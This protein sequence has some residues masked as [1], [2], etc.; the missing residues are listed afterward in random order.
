[1]NENLQYFIKS[2]GCT[3]SKN[4]AQIIEGLLIN[5]GFKKVKSIDIA[6]IIIINTCVVKINTENKILYLISKISKQMPEKILIITGCMAEVMSDRVT[7]IS[8][9]ANLIGP[10]YI[11]EIIKV[12]NEFKQNLRPIKL[13]G[14]RV[15]DKLNQ[16][17]QVSNNLIAI[18]PISQGCVNTCN[19]CIVKKA[20]G[21]LKSYP[22]EV[23]ISNISKVTRNGVKEI[24]LTAQDLS[25]Y[26]KDINMKLTDI[27]ERINNI[28]GKFR[29]RLGMM[30]P[31]TLL[32]NIDNLSTICK[33]DKF[34]K[35][36]HIPI[37]S[38][39]NEILEKMNRK[40]RIEDFLKIYNVIRENFNE[41]TLSTDIIC[42]YPG[43]T[44]DNFNNTLKIIKK[45]KPDIINISKYSHRPGTTASKERDLPTKVKKAR[46]TVL[47]KL[48]ESYT[49]EKLKKM[50]EKKYNVLYLKKISNRIYWGRTEKYSPVFVES[51]ENLI[52]RIL[53][54]KIID[55][56]E[57]QIIGTIV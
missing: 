53:K 1:M 52:G 9:Q 14:K 48:F 33:S 44:D 19:Y 16:P 35:F 18:I 51:N 37:Q 26:G 23:I 38:G 4:S 30:N 29:T 49:R 2:Y 10:F 5:N 56:K 8:P 24:Q 50:I 6:D 15:E 34:Y 31:S 7:S 36:F 22:I 43:E 41:F 42:G 28:T 12:I 13:I 46:S 39:D 11:T 17:K 32:P 21:Q 45:I 3:Y 27:L 20:M 47:Y 55:I 25:A 54:T 57:K 40:Y